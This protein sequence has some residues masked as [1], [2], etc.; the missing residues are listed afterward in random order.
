MKTCVICNEVH[1]IG[2][3]VNLETH[4]RDVCH[5]CAYNIF[6]QVDEILDRTTA[7]DCE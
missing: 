6:Q 4:M 1:T 7:E 3:Q 2:V 5:D